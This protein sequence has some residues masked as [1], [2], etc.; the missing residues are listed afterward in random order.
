MLLNLELLD[1]FWQ[2]IAPLLVDSGTLRVLRIH[3][4]RL[5]DL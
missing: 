3:M 2:G 1:Q 4:D 5:R